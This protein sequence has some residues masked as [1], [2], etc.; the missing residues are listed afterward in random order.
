MENNYTPV[1]YDIIYLYVNDVITTS[2]YDSGE[3]PSDPDDF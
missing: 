3:K 1:E 2:L